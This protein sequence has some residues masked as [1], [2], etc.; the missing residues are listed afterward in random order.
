MAE[1]SGGAPENPQS[2]CIH[3]LGCQIQRLCPPQK[4]K[5]KKF[6]KR[7]Y[8]LEFVEEGENIILDR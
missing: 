5:K 1:M 7:H 3:T 2:V 4:K 8:P 6:R